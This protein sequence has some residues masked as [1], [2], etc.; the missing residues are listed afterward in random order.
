M[1]NL[2]ENFLKRIEDQELTK[3]WLEHPGVKK[4]FFDFFYYDI[5]IIKEP[6]IIEFGVRHG[7]STT[8]FLDVCNINNGK[9]Y[10]IDEND[11]SY[12]FKSEKWNFIKSRDDNF[13]FLK[14]KLPNNVD[15]IFLDTLHKANHVIKILI[16]YFDN[17]KVRGYFIIDDISWIPY[18]KN[19]EHDHF[20]KEINNKET[21]ES[22]LQI[23]SLNSNTIDIKFNLTDTG[24]VI[25]TKLK[26]EKLIFNKKKKS[27]EGS[28]KNYLRLIYKKI[29]S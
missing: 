12:K 22:L 14:K 4:K 8:L 1:K 2:F 15:V 16:A 13:E 25:I 23:Y 21:F 19:N 10:S 17:L 3:I 9:M 18:L 20:Y 28:L 6:T 11:Y 26:N 27:R 24:S 5:S 29:F 7:I